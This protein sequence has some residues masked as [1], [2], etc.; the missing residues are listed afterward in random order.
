MDTFDGER[1]DA[2]FVVGRAHESH[3]VDVRERVLRF[4]CESPLMLMD[5][6]HRRS[7]RFATIHFRSEIR[8]PRSEMFQIFDRRTEADHAGDVWSSWLEFGWNLRVGRLFKADGA[9]HRS[10]ALVG[11]QAFEECALSIEHANAC[12]RMYLVTTKR[13]EIGIDVLNIDE[14]MGAGL[15]AID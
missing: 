7:H 3:A 15:C 10:A 9:Y 8:D 13:V 2:G 14:I 11:R 1:N 4:A 6:M 12:R 5:G